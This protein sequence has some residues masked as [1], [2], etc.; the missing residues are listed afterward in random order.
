M[1]RISALIALLLGA[2]GVLPAQAAVRVTPSLGAFQP[3]LPVVSVADGR[4]P[5]VELESAP[6][7][8][9]ELGVAP[10]RTPWVQL[11]GGLTYTTPRLYLSGAM[12]SQ[13]VNGTSTRATLL[14]PTAG[15]VLSPTLRGVPVRPTLRLGAG[16]KS[17]T[18]DLAEQRDRVT[19]LTGDVGLGFTTGRPGPVSFTAEARWLPSRFDARN[20]PIRAT[21]GRG[22]DQNDWMFQLGMRLNP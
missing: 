17:Y 9:L 13:P 4:N 10:R 5:D 2:P 21:G 1:K 6:A 18:F 7:V 14:I 19:D 12:E 22:Q 11:Y 20:L 8:G 15:V 16:V 3:M